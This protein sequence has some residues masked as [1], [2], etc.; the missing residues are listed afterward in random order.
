MSR[1]KQKPRDPM[2]LEVV[3]AIGAGRIEIGPIHDK[4]DWVSGI[5]EGARIRINPAIDVVDSTLHECLHRLRP[6]WVE[7]TVKA[8]TTRLMR[9]LSDAEIDKIYELVMSVGVMRRKAER[10]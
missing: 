7:R 1:K 5:C 4:D 6:A 9:Q 3:A 8:R 2:L 10:L